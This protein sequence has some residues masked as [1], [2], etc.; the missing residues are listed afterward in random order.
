V[1]P[2]ERSVVV[3]FVLEDPFEKSGMR[4]KIVFCVSIITI[5][6]VLAVSRQV[7][8]RAAEALR[9][10][11]RDAKLSNGCVAAVSHSAY[12]RVLLSMIL[13]E[14]LRD[15]ATRSLANGGISVVDIQKNG[16]TRR[17]VAHT[18]KLF[19]GGRA[20]ADF[21]LEIPICTV[22]RVNEARHLPLV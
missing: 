2:V 13:D 6:H 16:S 9:L 22:V 14:P 4:S 3:N 1:I 8:R 5:C 11:A 10:L 19:T 21:D 18:T 17:L 7:L 20:P 12:L 15:S